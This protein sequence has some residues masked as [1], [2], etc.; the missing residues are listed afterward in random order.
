MLKNVGSNWIVTLVTI[1]VTYFLMPFVLHTLGQDGYGTW[2]LINSI[3]GYLALLALGVPMASVR[4]FAEH[5]AD[6]DPQKLNRAIASCTALYLAIGVVA[7][8]VGLALFPFFSLTYD[9]PAAWRSDAHLAFFVVVISVALGLVAML[10]EGIMTA[11]DDF[12][13]RNV[14]VLGRLFVRLGLTVV[15]LHLRASL[16]FLALIQIACLVFDFSLSWVLIRRRYP[17]IRVRFAD[18][19]WRTVRRIFSF[20]LF[21]L[22]LTVGARLSFE[23]DA[24]VIGAFMDVGRIPFYTVANTLVIYLMEFVI[25][26]AAVVMPMATR[27]NA[28]GRASDLRD[29]FLK[30]S[31]IATSLTLMAGLFLIVLGPQFIGWWIGPSFEGPAGEVL[32]ILMISA[33]VFLPI[34]GVAQPILMGL[35]KPGIPTIA[36]LVAG[37]VNLGLSVL[38]VGPLGL[39][40]VAL[41]T[42]IPNVLFA[43]VILVLACRELDTSLTHYV[44]YVVGRSVIGALPVLALLLWFRLGLGIHTISGL[45]GAGAAMVIVFG[46]TGIL[47]VYRNDP[48]LDLPRGL[49]RLRGWSRV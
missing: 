19:D 36:F 14:V 40:G 21:V 10:P 12:V 13:V 2:A 4:Y 48:Y 49:A 22:L 42:A 18:F 1:A 45:V 38:L 16:V 6:R 44:R 37:V 17:E 5:A 23:T 8:L 33:L 9:L 35:G 46:L 20:S 41:G 28:Q 31:K 15:L 7:L 27:L 29:I 11:H 32:Q 30:W 47:F 39:A 3:T 43:L 24:I 34:R 25:A 26:I